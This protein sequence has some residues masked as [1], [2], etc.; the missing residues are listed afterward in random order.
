MIAIGSEPITV[1]G[2]YQLHFTVFTALAAFFFF[3]MLV[4]PTTFQLE[5]GLV[6]AGLVSGG[7]IVAGTR[8]R[9]SRD[10][11][12]LWLLTLTVGGGC[13][14]WGF[15]NGAPGALRVSTVYILWPAVYMLFVGLVHSPRTIVLFEKALIFGVAV[16]SFMAIAL[17]VGAMTGQAQ[18]AK[19]ILAFQGADIG[20]YAG[21]V[22]L[23]LFN[24]TTVIYGLP[25]LAALFFSPQAHGWLTSRRWIG[26]VLLLV[27]AV[28]VVSGRRAFWLLAIVTPALVW[29][30]F[31]MAGIRVRKRSV[32]V[33]AIS[34]V[35][36]AAVGVVALGLN[37][38]ALSDQLVSAFDFSGEQSASIRYQQYEALMSGWSDSPLIGHG[39]GASADLVTR[40][41]EQPWAY[42]LS[43]IGLLF[44]T[45]LLGLIIYSSAVLWVF[46]AGIKLVRL[47]PGT[48]QVILPL[49]AGLAGFLLINATNPYLWKFDYLWTIFLPVA[50]INAYK[51]GRCI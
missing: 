8:W 28:C 48:T 1:K 23:T 35:L 14:L 5:R 51:T 16:S 29:G 41:E 50:A 40:S 34:I 27:L 42:E 19:E 22:E 11:L 46:Y 49:L 32:G 18:L 36:V 6:L 31:L 7:L 24:L 4:L 2:V 25:Y 15:L 47:R 13:V 17:L 20:L 33:A 12:I 9:V 37:F 43:Y 21:F 10:I 3:L 26:L 30:L 39:L 44:Q 38:G 45:G